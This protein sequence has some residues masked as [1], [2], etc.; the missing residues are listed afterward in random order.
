MKYK[1]M[2]KLQTIYKIDKNKQKK[3]SVI[4][5]QETHEFDSHLT[6]KELQNFESQTIKFLFS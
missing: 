2:N 4:N 3:I 1:K 6:W 5:K